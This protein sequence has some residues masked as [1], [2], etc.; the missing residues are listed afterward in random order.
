MGDEACAEA[1]RDLMEKAMFY[2]RYSMTV[3]PQSF[4]EKTYAIICPDAVVRSRIAAKIDAGG[5]Q[6]THEDDALCVVFDPDDKPSAD[7]AQVIRSAGKAQTLSLVQFMISAGETEWLEGKERLESAAIQLASDTA[8]S[9][10]ETERNAWYI[11]ENR[12]AFLDL[13]IRQNIVAAAKGYLNNYL[14]FLPRGYSAAQN[15]ATEKRMLLDAIDDLISRAAAAEQHEMSAFLLRQKREL[16]ADAY[17]QHEAQADVKKDLGLQDRNAY[18]WLK[19]FDYS[20]E[21]DGIHIIGYRGNDEAVLIPAE[22][23]GKPVSS[24]ICRNFFAD[25]RKLKMHFC[26]AAE[27][28]LPELSLLKP[29]DSFLFGIYP[30]TRLGVCEPMEWLV[31]KK[32]PDRIL[33]ITKNCIDEL[34]FHRAQTAVNWE[35]CDLRRWLNG[36]FYQLSFSKNEKAR[37]QSVRNQNPENARYLTNCGADTE[38]RAFLLSLEEVQELFEN[39][40]SR[41]GSAT[42]YAQAQGMYYGGIVNCW[43]LRTSG[44]DGTFAAIVGNLGTVSTYGYSVDYNQYAVRPAMWIQTAGGKTE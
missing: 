8:F 29:G 41:I 5:A 18:D 10:E 6:I 43:W 13:I 26:R 34:P 28:K 39:D 16:F 22:I 21:P 32:E 19:L 4:K 2:D 40:E 35:N 17:V 1:G 3:L 20:Q 23:D 14:R 38:D 33:A 15:E 27:G 37:I 11:R 44:V 30:F 31:L 25:D 12:D 36:P 24:V 7:R 9:P 42:A